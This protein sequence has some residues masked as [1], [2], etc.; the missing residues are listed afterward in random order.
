[1]KK[2]IIFLSGVLLI[3]AIAAFNLNVGLQT[4]GT[5]TDVILKNNEARADNELPEVTLECDTSCEDRGQCWRV[6]CDWEPGQSD[7]CEKFGY[8]WSSCTCN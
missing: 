4:N 6:R 8:M 5:S 7:P 3:I 1:M 2:T